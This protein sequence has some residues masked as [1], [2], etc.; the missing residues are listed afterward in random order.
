MPPLPGKCDDRTLGAGRRRSRFEHSSPSCSLGSLTADLQWLSSAVP[1]AHSQPIRRPA[2]P[3]A[4]STRFSVALLSCSSRATC[5]ERAEGDSTA[6]PRASRPTCETVRRASRAT[7][8]MGETCN[9]RAE[10]P[11]QIRW[12]VSRCSYNPWFNF[13]RSACLASL[14]AP[15]SHSRDA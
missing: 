13:V 15:L 7:R 10:G 9:I 5:G 4:H 14:L 12:L 3:S 11:S 2:V 6:G 8:V 1:S